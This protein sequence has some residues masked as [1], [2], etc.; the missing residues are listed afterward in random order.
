MK[1][2]REAMDCGSLL[3]GDALPA[4]RELA[5]E[6][7]LS[8]VTVRKALAKLVEQGLLEKRRG[9]GTFVA[10]PRGLLSLLK[11]SRYTGGSP[12]DLELRWEKSEICPATSDDLLNLTM[13]PGEKVVR[14]S[15]TVYEGD[16]R[17]GLQRSCMPAAHHP[18]LQLAEDPM[19]CAV[20]FN[21][22][23]TTR[24][25]HRLRALCFPD[26]EADVLGV[27]SGSA[28]LSVERVRYAEGQPVDWCHLLVRGDSFEYVGELLE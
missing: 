22:L 1:R 19:A 4:E 7:K 21:E 11:I 16:V 6:L 12:R 24:S 14:L 5:F 18:S 9:A 27:V 17:I 15:G 3:P 23:S 26:D 13:K 8:R 20:A 28:A 2:L 25:L 10:A